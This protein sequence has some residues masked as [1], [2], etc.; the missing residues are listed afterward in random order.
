[1]DVGGAA[2]ESKLMRAAALLDTDPSRHRCHSTTGHSAQQLRRFRAGDVGVCRT[3]RRTARFGPDPARTWARSGR[4]GTG[5]TRPKSPYPRGGPG[6]E[7]RRSLARTRL[8]AR[9]PRRCQKLRCGVRKVLPA[10]SSRASSRRSGVGVG[11]STLRR[12]RRVAAAPPR[13]RT[14]RCG[15][16][17]HAG[18]AR[19][20]ARGL[21]R[22]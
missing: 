3:C 13:S 15:C 8:A 14:A 4:P 9:R 16:D 20:R 17:A 10:G 21:Y 18:R 2:I 6:A 11:R 19:G 1:M 12:S 5:Y 7:P 22:S